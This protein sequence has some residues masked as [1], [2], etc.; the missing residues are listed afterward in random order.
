M[1]ARATPWLLLRKGVQT[2]P[3]D[4]E[5]LLDSRQPDTDE[6]LKQ[7]KELT[8]QTLENKKLLKL[9]VN[10]IALELHLLFEQDDKLLLQPGLDDDSGLASWEL[11]MPTEP[12]LE[13]S[14]GYFWSCKSIHH[15]A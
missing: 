5:L 2:R 3:D 11:L 6:D 7:A 8:R 1:G 14:P 9:E 15:P 10:P 13:V 12:I 4:R